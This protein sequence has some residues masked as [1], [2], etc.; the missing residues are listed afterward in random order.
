[1]TTMRSNL[2][3]FAPATASRTNYDSGSGEEGATIQ[4]G[5]DGNR[6]KKKKRKKSHRRI[7]AVVS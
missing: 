2:S 5:P 7:D 3:K 6:I 4:T 1:M